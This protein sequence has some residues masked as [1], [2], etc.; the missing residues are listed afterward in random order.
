MLQNFP[1]GLSCFIYRSGKIKMKHL[2]RY[3]LITPRIFAL[4]FFLPIQKSIFFNVAHFSGTLHSLKTFIDL[5]DSQIANWKSVFFFVFFCYRFCHTA[6]VLGQNHYRE[7]ITRRLSSL[8][9]LFPFLL[10]YEFKFSLLSMAK[11]PKNRRHHW[12]ILK[13]NNFFDEMII[14]GISLY[15]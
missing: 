11:T 4:Y 9:N 10:I 2:S 7:V 6:V 8:R 5:N 14:K 12:L 3:F 15:F 13:L 1:V